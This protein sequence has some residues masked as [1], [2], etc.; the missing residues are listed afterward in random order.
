MRPHGYQFHHIL[1]PAPRLELG[2]PK[3]LVSKTSVSAIPPDG[4]VLRASDGDRTRDLHRDRVAS[5]PLL[6]R[7]MFRL[8]THSDVGE[9]YPPPLS[10][11]QVTKNPARS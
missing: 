11:S 5:T 4:H 1:V 10:S 7:R 2:R 9:S 6:H 3:A 8:L